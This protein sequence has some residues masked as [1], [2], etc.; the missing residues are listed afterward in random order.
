MR[1]TAAK[2]DDDGVWLAGQQ[3]GD[4]EDNVEDLLAF[5]M[6]PLFGHG[7]AEGVRDVE[8]RVDVLPIA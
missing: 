3:R 2:V 5:A 8:R 1:A 7:A 6:A 4:E